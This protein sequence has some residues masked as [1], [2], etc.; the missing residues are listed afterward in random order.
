M[1]G[2]IVFHFLGCNR[3]TFFTVLWI[4]FKLFPPLLF[5]FSFEHRSNWTNIYH[6]TNL[7]SSNHNFPQYFQEVFLM[8][9]LFT[10]LLQ[11]VYK[12]AFEQLQWRINNIGGTKVDRFYRLQY[13]GKTLVRDRLLWVN[14]TVSK[15][16]INVFKFYFDFGFA[17]LILLTI[18][19]LVVG[20]LFTH[21]IYN[22]SFIYFVS[23]TSNKEIKE[24]ATTG[25]FHPTESLN[26]NLS[27]TT[28]LK[29][30]FLFT[31]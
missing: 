16:F 26:I 4:N 5:R 22:Y 23:Q 21:A 31:L 8:E 3:T 12:T 17:E 7:L 6:K 2:I 1:F 27:S 28:A 10:Q 20:E 29:V 14:I 11:A 9:F 15:I 25:N 30:C 13:Q 18:S 24:N 19:L